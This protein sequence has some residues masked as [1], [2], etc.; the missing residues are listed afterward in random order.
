MNDFFTPQGWVCPKC[1]AVY[2]PS[3]PSCWNCKGN[4]VGTAPTAKPWPPTAP[5]DNPFN[6]IL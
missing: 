1:G 4:V 6:K 3:T 2:S 5:T